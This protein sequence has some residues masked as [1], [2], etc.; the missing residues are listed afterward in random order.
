[1]RNDVITFANAPYQ[2][3]SVDDAEN[4]LKP[5]TP[6]APSDTRQEQAEDSKIAD[7]LKGF[8]EDWRNTK[9]G[10]LALLNVPKGENYSYDELGLAGWVLRVKDKL[11]ISFRSAL[12]KVIDF[13]RRNPGPYLAQLI[14]TQ[15]VDP[16]LPYLLGKDPAEFSEGSSAGF[17][18]FPEASLASY[19][20]PVFE[21]T[22]RLRVYQAANSGSSLND[23]VRAVF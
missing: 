4:R 3:F 2:T 21:K 13:A 22:L 6:K 15:P 9:G 10:A 18:C 12:D 20:R 1:M 8:M 14:G 5:I 7:A 19:D 17:A 23:A 11:G 16:V